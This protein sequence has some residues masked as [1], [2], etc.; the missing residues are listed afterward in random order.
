M[1]IKLLGIVFVLAAFVA[2]GNAQSVVVTGKKITY[3]RPKPI[4]EYKKTF[5][6][7]YPKIK[8]ATPVLSKKIEA[9]ASYEKAFGFTL[10]EELGEIQWLETA[11]YEVIYNKNGI[12]CLSLFIE[13]SGAYPS[14]STKYVVVDTNTGLKQ[15]PA[16]LFTNLAGLA[17]LAKKQ[18]KTEIATAI[19]EIKADKTNEEPNPEHLFENADFKIKDLNDFSVDDKGV[20]FHYDYGFPHVIQGLQ[21]AGEFKFTWTQLKPYIK[22]GGLLSRMKG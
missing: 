10:K 7:N 22:N 3:N 20:T 16:N 4:S 21:P 17:A 12:L 18:Q 11:D 13:G 19:K 14:S 8:A 6:I 5:T 1:K 2:A 15:T 9:A